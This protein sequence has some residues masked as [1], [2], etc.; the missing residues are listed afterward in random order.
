MKQG[1]WGGAAETTQAQFP[2]APHSPGVR[3]R[4]RSFNALG[5]VAGLLRQTTQA[6]AGAPAL[7]GFAS[8]DYAG[9]VAAAVG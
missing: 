3:L 4:R 6:R 9:A 1:K 2:L 5:L 7:L 8:T